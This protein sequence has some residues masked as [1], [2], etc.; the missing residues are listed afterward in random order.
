MFQRVLRY[1]L[2]ARRRLRKVSVG[3]MICNAT[4][5]SGFITFHQ[6]LL[7][8]HREWRL[9]KSGTWPG[10]QLTVPAYRAD[11]RTTLCSSRTFCCSYALRRI[12]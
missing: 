2:V 6:P 8:L 12:A 4:R 7:C 9:L 10:V 3:C 1:K 5:F 11:G